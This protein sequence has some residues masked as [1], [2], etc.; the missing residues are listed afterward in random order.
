MFFTLGILTGIALCVFIIGF[1]TR[2]HPEIMK[3]VEKESARL[4]GEKKRQ[5]EIY[6]PLPENILK[7][8]QLIKENEKM[9]KDTP[10]ND[11]LDV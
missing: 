7:R 11:L 6:F 3:K 9:G 2:H 10:L 8:E 4:L 5:A 1:E